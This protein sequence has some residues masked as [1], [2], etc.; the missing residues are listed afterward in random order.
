MKNR[1]LS[2]ALHKF[3]DCSSVENLCDLL[4]SI[5]VDIDGEDLTDGETIDLIVDVMTFIR[6]GQTY[7]VEHLLKEGWAL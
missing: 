3:E 7:K 6:D 4:E 5:A 2:E 1:E